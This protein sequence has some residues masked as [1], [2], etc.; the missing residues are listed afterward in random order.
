MPARNRWRWP[1]GKVDPARHGAGV[2]RPGDLGG[3]VLAPATSGDVQPARHGVERRA[4]VDAP[5]CRR[6][7]LDADD[8][9]VLR[10]APGTAVRPA[11]VGLDHRRAGAGTGLLLLL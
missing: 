10:G 6:G 5:G 2:P 9:T 11:G 3:L 4:G 1:D 8:R 7:R